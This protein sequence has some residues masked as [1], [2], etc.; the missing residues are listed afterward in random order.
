MKTIEELNCSIV[1]PI[2]ILNKS[3][4]V[5]LPIIFIYGLGNTNCLINALIK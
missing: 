5:S 2:K 3:A 1:P 4:Y